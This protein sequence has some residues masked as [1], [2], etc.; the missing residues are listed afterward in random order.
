MM[1]GPNGLVLKKLSNLKIK[2]FITHDY[3]R[4]QRP[5][6]SGASPA[7]RRRPQSLTSALFLPSSERKRSSRTAE[8]ARQRLAAR[9]EEMEH[10][11]VKDQVSMSP[12]CLSTAMPPSES[13]Y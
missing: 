5:A 9:G 1:V 6:C 3:T 12:R 7:L 4:P 11:R 8:P 2:K 13:P 10:R